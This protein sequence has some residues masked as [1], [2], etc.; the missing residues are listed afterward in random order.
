MKTLKDF[1]QRLQ[2]DAAF[3]KQAQTFATGD[4]LMAFVKQ[5]GYD[6]TLEELMNEFKLEAESPPAAGGLASVSPDGGASLEPRPEEA[7]FPE[8]Q[9]ALPM[10][11]SRN[12]TWEDQLAG[13]PMPQGE[14]SPPAPQAPGEFSR[15]GGGRHRGFSPQRLKSASEE[16]P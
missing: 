11:G 1:I 7:K 8:A 2:D 10:S 9:A 15:L 12:F 4:E 6:F 14:M 3:E 16:E 5:E 13:L